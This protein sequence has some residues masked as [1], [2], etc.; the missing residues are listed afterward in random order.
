MK[1]IV[2]LLMLICAAGFYTIFSQP[3]SNPISSKKIISTTDSIIDER[4]PL[5]VLYQQID[6]A[7]KLKYEVFEM[8]ML[9]FDNL[10]LRNK[11]II[12]IVDFSLP[13]TDKRMYVIDLKNKK[14]LFHTIVSHGRNSGEKYAT[15]F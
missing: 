1:N 11:D 10:S 5:E 2:S 3:I 12:T 9:G 14:L 13:S 15:S 6:L 4:S 7:D 8:A